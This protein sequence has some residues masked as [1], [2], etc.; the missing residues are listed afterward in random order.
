LSIVS[1]MA[2]HDN[3]GYIY[4]LTEHMLTRPAL[5]FTFHTLIHTKKNVDEKKHTVMQVYFEYRIHS[6]H[7]KTSSTQLIYAP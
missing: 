6:S 5:I 3:T 1:T 2:R 7:T 4:R